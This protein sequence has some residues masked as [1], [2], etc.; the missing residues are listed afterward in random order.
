MGLHSTWELA[1]G[2]VV[3]GQQCGLTTFLLASGC[4]LEAISSL[5]PGIPAGLAT[6]MWMPWPR[7]ACTFMLRCQTGFGALSSAGHL[8]VV[9]GRRYVAH[10]RCLPRQPSR[11]R[12]IEADFS[13]V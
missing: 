6:P 5:G 4:K 9:I 11:S 13:L 3:T 8:R 1:M 10:G 12:G 2:S 7:V